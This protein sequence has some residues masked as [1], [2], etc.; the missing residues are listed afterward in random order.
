MIDTTT[1]ASIRS[2]L[3]RG[4]NDEYRCGCEYRRVANDRHRW[5]LCGYHEGYDDG[6]NAATKVQT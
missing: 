2:D 5:F 3:N 4:D 1:L 6:L